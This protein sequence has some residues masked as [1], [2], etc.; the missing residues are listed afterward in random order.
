MHA[1]FIEKYILN[2]E[3][4][5]KGISLRILDS[6]LKQ[7]STLVPIIKI[8]SILKIDF[9]LNYLSKFDLTSSK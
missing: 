8:R 9:I 5:T 6:L 7:Y 4:D 3:R 2:F 1:Y